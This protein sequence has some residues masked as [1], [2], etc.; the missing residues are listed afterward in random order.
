LTQ[1]RQLGFT[2]A[3]DDFGTGYSSLSLLRLLPLERLKVDRSFVIDMLSDPVARNVTS[4]VIGLAKTLNLEVVAEG[5][6][7]HDHLELLRSLGC[8]YA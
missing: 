8:D 2:I 6:E 5:V 7:T 4:A 1:L 3:L